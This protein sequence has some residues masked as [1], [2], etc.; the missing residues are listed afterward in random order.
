MT[1]HPGAGDS[2][3]TGAASR[4]AV[5]RLFLVVLAAAAALAVAGAGS[6]T[7]T[8]GTFAHG[9]TTDADPPELVGVRGVDPMTINV[10][11]ADNHDVDE[12]SI[13][14]ETFVLENREVASVTVTER[15]P[16]AT[17]TLHLQARSN[18]NRTV[19]ALASGSAVADTNGNAIDAGESVG[20]TATG[21][22]GIAPGVEEFT[23][24]DATGGPATITVEPTERLAGLNLTLSGVV[25]DRLRLADFSY[26]EPTD[27]YRT[28]YAPPTDGTLVVELNNATDTAGNSQG[29]YRRVEVTVDRTGP[30]TVAGIDFAASGNLS[31]TFDAGRSTD[32][33]GIANFTWRFGD[34]TRATGERV[35]HAFAPGNYTVE[36]TAVDR[37]GNVGRDTLELNL[38]DGAGDAANATAEQ[39]AAIRRGTDVSVSRAGGSPGADALVSVDRAV[40]GTPVEIGTAG[41]ALLVRQGPVALAGLNVT[42]AGNRSFG[43]GLS[44]VPAD[45][46]GL[47]GDATPIGGLT[48]VH[49]VPDAE[50]E[51]AIFEFSVEAARLDALGVGPD[52][53]SLYRRANGSWTR[54]PTTVVDAGGDAARFRATSPGFSQFV[55]AADETG[56]EPEGTATPAR[57]PTPTATPAPGGGDVGGSG[58]AVRSVSLNAS[59]VRVGQV[60]GVNATVENR[61]EEFGVYVAGLAVNGTVVETMT[62]PLQAGASRGVQFTYAPAQAGTLAVAVNGTAGGTLTVEGGGGLL[63]SIFGFLPLGL[64]QPVIVFLVVPAL[65]VYL[66]LKGLAIYLGY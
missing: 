33:A 49:D 24:T 27:T 50:I 38:T 60:V 17:A 54:L 21:M 16:N 28:T 48:V 63:G 65:V 30:E 31:L 13:T 62:V 20:G 7:V 42:L 41:D 2:G 56:G 44:A 47:D 36:L 18:F 45:A 6:A 55:V 3:A 11:F 4:T 52:A 43:L 46:A 1:P 29:V 23:V 37:Y 35:S 14:N 34:G 57:T 58:F 10:T 5:R 40:G 51:A 25:D 8:D 22:D 9:N 12:G 32:P 53:V 15:G 59:T 19:V 61:G 66:A 39:I 26:A 64:L